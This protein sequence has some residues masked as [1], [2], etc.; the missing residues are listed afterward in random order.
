[1]SVIAPVGVPAPIFSSSSSARAIAR[2]GA[3]RSM[4]RSKR[5]D[6]SV[7]RPSALLVA[8]ICAG[9]KYAASN[10]T[11]VVAVVISELAP[12]I[13]PPMSSAWSA[14]AITSMSAVS[15][16]FLPSSVVMVSPAW[17]GAP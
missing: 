6:A 8:R 14:S 1:M 11:R 4:P 7:L 15:V 9:A 5:V 12:P 10:T 17:R 13:T 16:R 3:V 2:G